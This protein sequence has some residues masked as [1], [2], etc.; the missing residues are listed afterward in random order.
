MLGAQVWFNAGSFGKSTHTGRAKLLDRRSDTREFQTSSGMVPSERSLC[1]DRPVEQSVIEEPG[2]RVGAS[3]TWEAE[4]GRNDSASAGRH[5][6]RD[7]TFGGRVS[8]RGQRDRGHAD[9]PEGIDGWKSAAVAAGAARGRR[10]CA[11][12]CVRER[13]QLAPGAF[14]GACARVCGSRRAG[15]GARTNCAP[16]FD[17]EYGAVAG[18]RW[19][20]IARSGV[21]HESGSAAL[22]LRIAA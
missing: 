12:D 22:A 8:G 4:T 16:A 14:G 9:S 20:R 11:A 13:R 10:I 15:R 2:G 19:S 1:P 21:G 5:V 7:G 6:A 3:R 17:G 18:G